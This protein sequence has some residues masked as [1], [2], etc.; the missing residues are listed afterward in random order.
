MP[1]P[2]PLPPVS[3][4]QP[5]HAYPI[6]THPATASLRRT[7]RERIERDGPLGFADFMAAALYDPAHGYYARSTRQTGKAGDFF[8]SVSVGPVFGAVLARRLLQAWQ[9]AGRPARWRIIECGAH[10]GTLA[11]DVLGTLSALDPRASA[12]LEY[13]IPEPLPSLRAAQRTTLQHY[14]KCVR[15]IND[16]LELAAAPLPGVA[17]GNEVLD[18]LPCH[19][20]ERHANHWLE[21]QVVLAPDGEFAWTTAAIADPAL[22]E[23]LAP[24]GDLFPQGYRT[25]VR[26]CFQS[27]LTPLVDGL[28]SGLMLWIDY[29]FAR[30]DYYHPDRTCGTLR[31]FAN[32]RAGTNQ[33]E[34]P[35]ATDI[36]AHVDFTAVAEA[37]LALGGRP[38]VF[39]NQGEWLTATARSWLL[40][41]E[42]KPQ[43]AFLRQFQTL[44]HP[45][46][47]GS[48]FHVLELSW[49]P[50]TEPLDNARLTRQL[51]IR[52]NCHFDRADS[53]LA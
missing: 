41:Q 3:A 43:P 9:D 10:D 30:P 32:H 21:C 46:H 18:A 27:F 34:R 28:V 36:T 40:E 22:L 49:N 16:P 39:R 2:D 26:T 38:T 45:A 33:L 19:L 42:G 14:Q 15:V 37:A 20:V 31:T 29:G 52:P 48:R 44:T 24:L 1:D 51:T 6:A 11:V 7:L 47:L 13:V 4:G 12:A 17:F 53:F 8:T 50:T 25:E 35:G 23:A 5:P